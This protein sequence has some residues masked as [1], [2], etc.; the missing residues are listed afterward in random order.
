MRRFDIKQLPWI[1]TLAY[2]QHARSQTTLVTRQ[3]ACAS[4][5]RP[6]AT[7]YGTASSLVARSGPITGNSPFCEVG[8]QISECGFIGDGDTYGL[9]IR[10]GVYTQWVSSLLAYSFQNIHCAFSAPV[11]EALNCKPPSAISQSH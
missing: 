5:H 10:L 1:D 4:Y 8:P 6:C 7:P 3:H 2:M 11:A 9:G